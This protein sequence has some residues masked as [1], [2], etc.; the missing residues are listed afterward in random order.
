M[1]HPTDPAQSSH[2]VLD[3]QV[4]QDLVESLQRPDTVA[5]VYRKFVENAAAFI[6]E[7]RAQDAAARIE[8]L[9]TL[10][11]SAAMMGANSLAKLAADLQSQG[12]AVQVEL[13]TLRLTEELAKF[14][15]AVDER[16]AS[17]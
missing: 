15:A 1:S 11:G 17:I 3:A 4:F 8:T 10:K 9:H 7:L 6:A 14:R 2:N 13:A 5:A 16:F 12:E